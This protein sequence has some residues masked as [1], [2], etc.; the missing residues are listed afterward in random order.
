MKELKI[1]RTK[2]AVLVPAESF[3]DIFIL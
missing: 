2:K 3:Q 1:P